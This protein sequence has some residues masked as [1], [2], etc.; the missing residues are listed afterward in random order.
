MRPKIR[1]SPLAMTKIII[2]MASPA[3]VRVI[4]LLM[5]PTSGRATSASN[6][7]RSIHRR[8][9]LGAPSPTNDPSLIPLDPAITR[10]ILATLRG[11]P[12][13]V[14]EGFT[15]AFRKR[16]QVPEEATSIADRILQK[17]HHD[18]IESYLVQHQQVVAT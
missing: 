4:Q 5:L 7:T 16:F 18:W 12:R 8:P 2:P 3:T 1:V 15:K 10:Q 17:Q 9:S 14:L 13:P 11:L 6:G